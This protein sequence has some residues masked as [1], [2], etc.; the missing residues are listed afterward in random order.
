M[1]Y[2]ELAAAVVR[3]DLSEKRLRSYYTQ[4][5][6]TATD[7]NRR[8]Q[9]SEFGEIADPERFLTLRNLTT[10]SALLH[11]IADV[12][13]YLSSKR[14]TIKGQREM[15]DRYIETAQAHGMNIDES[16]YT[17]W[18]EFLKWF[19]DSAYALSFDSDAEEVEAAFEEGATPA[20][21]E[22]IFSEYV[23]E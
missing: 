22:R 13:R 16:N 1:S 6:R 21:W 20:D 15:R 23:G 10:Q 9:S 5:R 4:A 19:K 8:V 17:K 14:S 2:N 7:R 11:E 18:I 3:G 12:N